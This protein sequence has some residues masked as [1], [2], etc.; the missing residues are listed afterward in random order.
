MYTVIIQGK[1]YKHEYHFPTYNAMLD[2]Y[3]SQVNLI[4]EGEHLYYTY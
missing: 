1:N 4:K 2:Y 3:K